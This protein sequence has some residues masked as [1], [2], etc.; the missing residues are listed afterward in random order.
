MSS[1][2]N[3]SG[4]YPKNKWLSLI[5]ASFGM[6]IGSLDIAVNSPVPNLTSDWLL[7]AE[8]QRTPWWYPMGS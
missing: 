7:Q 8:K 2:S 3:L 5:A 1:A 6:F 4:S